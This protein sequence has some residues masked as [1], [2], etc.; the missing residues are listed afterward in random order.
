MVDLVADNDSEIS[1]ITFGNGFGRI[2]DLETGPNGFLY[3]LSYE[4]GIVYRIVARILLSTLMLEELLI[5]DQANNRY[6]V[7]TI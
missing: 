3:I 1:R 2:T 6:I 7:N 5:L 4:P